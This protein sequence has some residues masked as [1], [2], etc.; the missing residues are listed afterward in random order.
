MNRPARLVTLV[1]L[2]GL[3]LLHGVDAGSSSRSKDGVVKTASG[4]HGLDPSNFVVVL[5]A[6]LILVYGATVCFSTSHLFT[7]SQ[8]MQRLPSS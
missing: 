7:L 6:A 4:K 1:L 5:I 3:A 2:V 8:P